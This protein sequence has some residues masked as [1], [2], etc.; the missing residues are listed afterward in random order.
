MGIARK[1]IKKTWQQK[2]S[3]RPEKS[4]AYSFKYLPVFPCNYFASGCCFKHIHWQNLKTSNT[5]RVKTGFENLGVLD[6]R[7]F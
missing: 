5:G 4:T 7:G 3:E 1:T 6:E 2:F